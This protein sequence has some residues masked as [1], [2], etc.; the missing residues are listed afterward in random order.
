VTI[1]GA[2]VPA[3]PGVLGGAGDLRQADIRSSWRGHRGCGFSA[4]YG[5]AVPGWRRLPA[6]RQR[7]SCA[8]TIKTAIAGEAAEDSPANANLREICGLPLASPV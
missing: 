6:A 5:C 1:G 3:A 4:C 2:A 8:A 7:R